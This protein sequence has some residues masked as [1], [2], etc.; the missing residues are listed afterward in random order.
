[1]NIRSFGAAGDGVTD[2]AKAFQN[3]LDQGGAWFIPAGSYL[4]GSPLSIRSETHIRADPSAVVKLGD[5]ALRRHGDYLLSGNDAHDITIEGGI[6]DGNAPGN[7]RDPDM[8][9]ADAFQGCMLSFRGVRGLTLR[10]MTWRDPE[11]FY[12]CLCETKDFLIEDIVFDSPHLR[13]NQDGIHMAGFCEHGVI[14]RLRGLHGSPNDDII[15]L[16]ADDCHTRIGN[17][18]TVNGPIR[19]ITVED[20][21][22]E[23]CHTFVRIASIWS[24][25]SDIRIR[26]LRGQFEAWGVN[27]DALRYC[28][29]PLIPPDDPAFT[30]GVGHVHDVRISDLHISRADGRMDPILCLETDADRMTFENFSTDSACPAFVMRNTGR[31]R[32]TLEGAEDPDSLELLGGAVSEEG[33]I[34]KPVGGE[35]RLNRGGFAKLHI[36]REC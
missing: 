33:E 36:R 3:A 12:I 22:A 9:A 13:P 24:E 15:A 14:R 2:D 18:E 31:C 34:L 23:R 20:V 1:K 27:M 30:N 16:N 19:D 21:E 17:Q 10:N 4:I 25:V 7:P 6:W 28:R 32:L 26:G 29:T 8:F 35:V 5:G 11:T